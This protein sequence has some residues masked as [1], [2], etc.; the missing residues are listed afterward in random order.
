MY[1]KFMGLLGERFVRLNWMWMEL[2]EELF[3]KYYM[4][5]YWYE[6]NKLRNIVRFFGYLLLLDLIGWYV[7]LIIY[8]NEEEMMLVSCI[9]IKILFEDL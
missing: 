4:M 7:F 9:F 3:M 8:L 6:M 5:I 1:F 2:F